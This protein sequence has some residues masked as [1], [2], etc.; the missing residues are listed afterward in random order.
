V[1]KG[2]TNDH[3]NLV[4]PESFKDMVE[5]KFEGS[6]GTHAGITLGQYSAGKI[7]LSIEG[8]GSGAGIE[9]VAAKLV[10][11]DTDQEIA[12]LN[13]IVLPLRNEI[14]VRVYVI[15]DP[16]STGTKFSTAPMITPPSNQLILDTLNDSFRQA[17]V[18]FKIDAGSTSTSNPTN[19]EYDDNDDGL[20]SQSEQETHVA[21][22]NIDPNFDGIRV[23]FVKNSGF[24]YPQAPQHMVRGFANPPGQP[25]HNFNFVANSNG[26]THLVVAHEIA[27]NLGLSLANEEGGHDQPPYPKEVIGD[28]PNGVAPVFPGVPHKSKPNDA[29]LQAGTPEGQGVSFRLPWIHGRWIRHEDWEMA[30]DTAKNL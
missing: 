18:R 10:L 19:I 27:H 11:K 21:P 25:P 9:P 16:T 20:M 4:I 12:R 6:G 24:P 2:E 26:Y 7:D 3:I 15:E 30:N 23:Y 17:G 29:L 8:K 13:I 28:N 14:A 5:F 1:V 22:S